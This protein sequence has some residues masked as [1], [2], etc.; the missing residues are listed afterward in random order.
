VSLAPDS[1]RNADMMDTLSLLQI[2]QET[3]LDAVVPAT[4][5]KA[6]NGNLEVLGVTMEAQAGLDPT[7]VAT[8]RPTATCDGHLA[9]KL[10]I[11]ANYLRKTREQR[12]DLFDA[13]VNG[14]LHG[15]DAVAPGQLVAAGPDPRRFLL[16]SFV[17]P[18]GGPGVARALLSD[19][20]RTIDHLDV[21]TAAMAGLRDSEAEVSILGCD[22]TN[23]RLTIRVAAPGIA[24]LA[25]ELFKGYR[26]PVPA[27]D[28]AGVKET[29]RRLAAE[30]RGGMFP[31]GE[32]PIVFAGFVLK[33]SETGGG[34]YTIT[35]RIVALR[36]TNGMTMTSDALRAVHLGAKLEEGIVQWSEGTLQKTLELI[37]SKT[38]DAVRT[39]LDVEYVRGVI[40][41]L[42]AKAGVVLSDPVKA[43]EV[44][45][46]ELRFSDATRAGIMSH[47]IM[48]G[49]ITSG[50]IM[51]A[52]T[53]Y[54]QEPSLSADQAQDLEDV[55]IKALDLAAAL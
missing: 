10:G 48:G 1:T 39:F 30:G 4:A 12:P 13:N 52:I 45:G 26:S 27:W 25:P 8:F 17:D 54:A 29:V 14:W 55:A 15:T 18:E 44:I 7:S 6:V 2:Q 40:A 38:A 49:Q 53:S 34:A 42:E 20:Y 22:L 11:P 46:K 32:E 9:E 47:F 21:A 50:G 3:K 33:N 23:D 31:A 51:Q 5:V 28:G 37:Q 43:V 35:P 41:K 16:R 19:S 36:C 24:V